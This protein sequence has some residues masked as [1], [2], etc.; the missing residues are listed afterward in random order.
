M[1]GGIYRRLRGERIDS[2]RSVCVTKSEIDDGIMFLTQCGGACK[3]NLCV[4]VYKCSNEK[5]WRS[6][7]KSQAV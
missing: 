4:S 1:E 2:G 3:V 7:V 6:K 5:T